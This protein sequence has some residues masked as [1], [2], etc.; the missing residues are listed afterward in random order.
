M[1]IL[2]LALVATTVLASACGSDDGSRATG[3][4]NT[5]VEARLA[6]NLTVQIAAATSASV[7]VSVSVT[8]SLQEPVSGGICAELVQ[9]RALSSNSWADVTSDA[10][11]CSTIA[12]LLRPGETVTLSGSADRA[13]LRAA[14]GASANSVIVRVRHTL[15]GASGAYLMQ[16]NELTIG[17]N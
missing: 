1:K 6:G 14:A 4:M 17:L 9:A 10:T 7:P 11:V 5:T 3:S 13:K 12:V 2:R 16:S 8:S 15:T